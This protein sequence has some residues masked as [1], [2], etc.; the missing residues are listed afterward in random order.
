MTC[1]FCFSHILWYH[2]LHW[3]H[4]THWSSFPVDIFWS[5]CFLL[6]NWHSSASL[7]SLALLSLSLLLKYSSSVVS[8][9][10]SD[11]DIDNDSSIHV[12]LWMLRFGLCVGKETWVLDELA[13]S[14]AFLRWTASLS[15]LLLLFD[16][17][18]FFY[19][20]DLFSFNSF[21]LSLYQQFSVSN[22]LTLA[23]VPLL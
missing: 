14:F 20:A 5:G 13:F 22:L 4:W 10:T 7:T 12:F 18:F 3:S 2:L 11:I 6:H 9:S 23:L 21:S 1:F 8:V 15:S 16:S 17:L 19:S